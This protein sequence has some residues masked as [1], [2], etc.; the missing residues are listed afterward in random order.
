MRDAPI[1]YAITKFVLLMFSCPLLDLLVYPN[2]VNSYPSGTYHLSP[3]QDQ[4]L[5]PDKILKDTM[6]FKESYRTL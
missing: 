2:I 4:Y 5:S 1:F 6:G 3:Y